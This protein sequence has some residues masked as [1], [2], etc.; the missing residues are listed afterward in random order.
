MWEG[1]EAKRERTNSVFLLGDVTASS[2]GSSIAFHATQETT[3]PFKILILEH[4][5]K[6]FT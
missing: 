3:A 2:T 1:G 6:H 4:L 5:G